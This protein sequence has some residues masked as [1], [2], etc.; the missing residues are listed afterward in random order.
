MLDGTL[1]ILGNRSLLHQDVGERC[2]GDVFLLTYRL[3]EF[4]LVD[5]AVV[6]CEPPKES[7]EKAVRPVAWSSQGNRAIE[8]SGFLHGQPEY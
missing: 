3:V 6:N 4:L 1:H 8:C 5:K 2:R 7:I